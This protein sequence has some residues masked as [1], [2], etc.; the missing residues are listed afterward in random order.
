M[1][2]TSHHTRVQPTSLSACLTTI[3]AAQ[4]P[5]TPDTGVIIAA[6]AYIDTVAFHAIALVPTSVNDNA[7]PT[8]TAGRSR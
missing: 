1:R 4:P 3:R 8:A 5:R 2:P 7:S 6:L